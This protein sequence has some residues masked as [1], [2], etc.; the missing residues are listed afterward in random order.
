MK[1]MSAN[2]I[3]QGDTRKDAQISL[4]VL[5]HPL[6]LNSLNLLIVLVIIFEEKY[7][8][9]SLNLSGDPDRREVV[10]SLL[11]PLEGFLQGSTHAY[12]SLSP[13]SSD[14]YLAENSS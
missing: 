1:K 13:L 5:K 10:V 3:Q 9:R 2:R 8:F 6:N 4:L 14:P 7:H 12:I 11:S